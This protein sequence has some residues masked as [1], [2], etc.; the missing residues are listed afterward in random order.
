MIFKPLSIQASGRGN[1]FSG[2]VA[3]TVTLLQ[4]ERKITVPA[5]HQ[6]RLLHQMDCIPS[7][8]SNTTQ[9]IEEKTVLFYDL[10]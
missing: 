6:T 5:S 10:R 7:M 9:T 8:K 1:L 2:D 3:R 4:S